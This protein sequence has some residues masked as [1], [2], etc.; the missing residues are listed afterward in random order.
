MSSTL[1]LSFIPVSLIRCLDKLTVISKDP[2]KNGNVALSTEPYKELLSLDQNES[3][4]GPCSQGKS[5]N[6]RM[7]LLMML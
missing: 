6:K 3:S 4:R 2:C 1:D 7:S 5:T